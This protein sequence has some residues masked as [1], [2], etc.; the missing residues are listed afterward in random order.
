MNLKTFA[1]L[2][3]GAILFEAGG[4]YG[5]EVDDYIAAAMA[6]QHIPGLSLAV[7]RDGKVIKSQAY[8]K[9]CIE[10]NVAAKPEN[11]YELASATKPLVAMGVVLLVQKGKL[12]LDDPIDK[13]IENIPEAWR[14]VTIR[15]LLSHTSGIK[16]YLE[17]PEMTPFDLPPEKVMEIAA[18]FP[19]NFTPGEKWAYSNTGYVLLGMIIE[20]VSGKALGAYLDEDI[21]KPIGMVNTHQHQPDAVILNRAEGYLWLGPGGLRNAGMFK[22]MMSNRGDAGVLST[23][24]DLIKFDAALMSDRLLS[25]ASRKAMW[26]QTLL[27][28]VRLASMGWAGSLVM[29]TG[30]GTSIIPAAFRA[31]ARSSHAIRTRN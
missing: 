26:T 10:L 4:A 14:S 23:V 21:F 28:T 20:K 3:L 12:S 8:G 22:Y 2:S 16:D 11:V 27:K 7:I 29:S 24:D 31:L 18:G 19:L 25:P 30:T 17:R 9:A 1:A 6:R 15:H 5:D 13:F